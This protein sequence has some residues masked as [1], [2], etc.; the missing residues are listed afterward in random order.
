MSWAALG[1]N[2]GRF[3]QGWSDVSHT[4]LGHPGAPTYKHLD[5]GFSTLFLLFGSSCIL[6]AGRFHAGSHNGPCSNPREE[7]LRLLLLKPPPLLDELTA[8]LC[9][10]A[11]GQR[12]AGGLAPTVD[13]F[14]SP[15][16]KKGE[17]SC[18][19]HGWPAPVSCDRAEMRA[20]RPPKLT[21]CLRL[22]LLLWPMQGWG[23]GGTGA[24]PP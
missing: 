7:L 13:T 11:P 17:R 23:R 9:H 6:T 1:I 14:L 2:D 8:A 3:F 12:W 16:D 24:Q 21:Q 4:F 5:P 18:S 22:F 10:S 15:P 20:L 19:Q